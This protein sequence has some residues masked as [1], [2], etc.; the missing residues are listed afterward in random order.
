[1]WEV[2][3]LANTF[4]SLSEIVDLISRH[5]CLKMLISLASCYERQGVSINLQ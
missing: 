1:M 5:K 3:L 4:V 2:I